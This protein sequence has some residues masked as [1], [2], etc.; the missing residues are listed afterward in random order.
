M[1]I[2]EAGAVHRDLAARNIFMTENGICKIG[3]FGLARNL[4][5]YS[6]SGD[7]VAIKWAAPESIT[8]GMFSTHT[9]V[10]SY[11][12]FVVGVVR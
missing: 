12:I 7:N 11:G 1:F 8:D 2:S 4:Q 3:D 6:A 5:Y 9:D 10:W